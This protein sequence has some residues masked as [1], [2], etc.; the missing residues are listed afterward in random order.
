M[1]SFPFRVDKCHINLAIAL[2]E[3]L[4]HHLDYN[5]Y[6]PL[7]KLCPS[8]KKKSQCAT[9]NR[10]YVFYCVLKAISDAILSI[11]ATLIYLNY[12]QHILLLKP[13]PSPQ[14]PLQYVICNRFYVSYSVMAAIL[15]SILNAV[16]MLVYKK[17]TNRMFSFHN[18]VLHYKNYYNK[19]S[20]ICFMSSIVC[21]RPF[22]TPFW[23]PF[24]CWFTKI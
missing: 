2:M 14:K 16:N 23:T 17:I 19:S 6:V 8:M 5:W 21:W 7:P 13:C 4:D 10:F 15:D 12:K 20:G 3:W 22:W 9:C 1:T 11:I 18:H 24:I